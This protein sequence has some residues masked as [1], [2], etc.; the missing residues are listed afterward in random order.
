MRTIAFATALLLFSTT[1]T[2][3]DDP[4]W[5]R[6]GLTD[7]SEFS[8]RNGSFEVGQTKGGKAVASLIVQIQRKAT[9]TMDYRR[10]YVAT[11]D[12][13]AGIGKVVVLDTDGTYLYEND[14][15]EGGAS[16]ASSGG[17]LICRVYKS[18]KAEQAQKGM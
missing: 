9:K 3:E 7:E 14:Y 17:D 16:V 6:F 11:Q 13:D 2:A 4:A 12:C 8:F 18:D 15:V 1:S 5:T 10:W